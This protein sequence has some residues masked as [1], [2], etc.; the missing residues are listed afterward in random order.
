MGRREGY[1]DSRRRGREGEKE[2]TDLNEGREEKE[3]QNLRRGGWNGIWRLDRRRSNTKRGLYP[4]TL[5]LIRLIAITCPCFLC[6]DTS[7]S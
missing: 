3:A 5:A 2:R 6:V 7:R 4:F 1:E